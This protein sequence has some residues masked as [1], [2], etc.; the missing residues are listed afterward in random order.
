MVHV[1]QHLPLII[2]DPVFHSASMIFFIMLSE[3]NV[4]PQ[5]GR[6]QTEYCFT[7][8]TK[9]WR[10]NSERWKQKNK[11]LE[12]DS[13]TSISNYLTQLSQDF[14]YKSYKHSGYLAAGCWHFTECQPLWVQSGHSHRSPNHSEDSPS[15]VG[16]GGEV[17]TPISA[18]YYKSHQWL[19]LEA[20]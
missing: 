18:N 10:L 20:S 7:D 17:L 4:V 9:P 15:L 13:M 8:I 19:S 5:V 2:R 1:L 3:Y 6:V 16:W 14:L 12:N 11:V